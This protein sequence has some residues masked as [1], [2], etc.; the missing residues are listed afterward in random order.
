[1]QC[2]L[3][4]CALR[5]LSALIMPHDTSMFWTDRWHVH[6]RGLGPD[7][8]CSFDPWRVQAQVAAARAT[9]A[10][11]VA[12]FIHWGPNCGCFACVG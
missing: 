1:M 8:L 6:V 7:P 5:L 3:Q 10:D 12:V 11:L 4:V 2:S 9:H